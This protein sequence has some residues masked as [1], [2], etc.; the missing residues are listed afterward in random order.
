MKKGLKITLIIL[1]VLVGIIILDTL[2][3]RIFKTS[4]IISWKKQLD[5]DSYVERGIL[6]DTYYCVKEKDIVTVS[7]KLKNSKFTCPIE[8][9]KNETENGLDKELLQC[10]ENELG[11]YLVTEKAD[12]IEIPLSE[13]KNDDI[14]KIEYYKGVYAS[15]HSNNMYVIVYPKNGTYDSTVMK[16]FDKYFYERF[17]MY[18]T[19]QSPITP[20]IYIHNNDNSV[21]FNEIINKC[22][23]KNNMKD[24]KSIPT[25]TMNKIN[26][27][28]KIVIK[29]NNKEIGT[30]TNKEKLT[31]ILGTISNSKQYGSSYLCDNYAFNFEMYDTSNKLIDTIYVWHDGKRLIP[32]SIEND[33]CSYYSILNNDNLRQIIE[34]ETDYVF[35]NI[36]DFR[37]D[38][39][40][41]TETL[42]YED[43]TNSYYLK[44]NAN[45]ILIEFMLNNKV[46]MLKYA[47]ENK[48]ISAEKVASE[49]PD[50][51]IK[52]YK[53]TIN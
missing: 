32:A 43:D 42:I 19:Y 7:W 4:P 10:L 25:E 5:G 13:I 33:G 12:L 37:N 9:L 40:E 35:Y 2:Q 52:K 50:V 41:T 27:T 16:D 44:G 46:M 8:D 28:T 15:E 18:Q 45:E 3:A 34:E 26:E 17:S 14:D 47:L 51:L 11:G 49:Y 31:E 53:K 29:K 38:V 36:L 39:S 48:Y 6:M 20:T 24:G 22:A 21:N 30:I 23:V 1:G